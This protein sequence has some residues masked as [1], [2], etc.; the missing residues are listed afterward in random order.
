MNTDYY[1]TL[2]ISFK[3]TSSEIKKAYRKLALL[4]HPDRNPTNPEKY[5]K[6]FANINEAYKILS[7]EKSRKRYNLTYKLKITEKTQALTP[8]YFLNMITIVK[9]LISR[10]SSHKISERALNTALTSL[11]SNNNLKFLQDK[12][13]VEINKKIIKEALLCCNFLTSQNR[14]NIMDKLFILAK[15]QVEL[16]DIIRKYIRSK[17]LEHSPISILIYKISRLFH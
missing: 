3:A 8:Y 7:D 9:N 14:K 12:N 13:E 1:K 16:N 2:G 4:Y 15:D 10:K 11:L 6:I 17:K 5:Q